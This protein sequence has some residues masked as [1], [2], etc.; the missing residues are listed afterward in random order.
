MWNSGTFRLYRLFPK[1]SHGSTFKN[2]M[3]PIMELLMI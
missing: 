3:E 2:K 1:A